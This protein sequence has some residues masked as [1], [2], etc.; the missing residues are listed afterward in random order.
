V[1]VGGW[2]LVV[3]GSCRLVAACDWVLSAQLTAD[4]ATELSNETHGGTDKS[5]GRSRHF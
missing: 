4:M 5:C 1:V 2:C 3:G